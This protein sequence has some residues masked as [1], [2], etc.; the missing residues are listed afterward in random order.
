MATQTSDER[1]EGREEAPRELQG[2]QRELRYTVVTAFYDIGRGEWND[3]YTRST[4]VYF[5]RAKRLFTIPDPMVIFVDQKHVEFVEENRKGKPTL[6]IVRKFEDLPLYRE[7][8]AIEAIMANQAFIQG[9]ADHAR[10]DPQFH[11]P[12]YNI[13]NWSKSYFLKTAIDRN[14]FFTSH[15]L[16]VDFGIQEHMLTDDMLG[17]KLF[18]EGVRDKISMLAFRDRLPELPD[19]DIRTFYQKH[20][21][22]LAGTLI[23]GRMDYL[24]QFFEKFGNEVS[25]ALKHGV[26]GCDQVL[27]AQIYLKFPDMFEVYYGNSWNEIV[28]GYCQ[29]EA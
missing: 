28:S 29:T 22:S 8:E 24:L 9:V 11:K 17:K 4:E 1:P 16:W 5:R 2:D 10:G 6:V 23:T 14:E 13:I 15:F 7:K 19:L 18:P 21:I 12:A 20:K 27:T 25:R 3:Y 26:L